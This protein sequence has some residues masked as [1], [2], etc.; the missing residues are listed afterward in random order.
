MPQNQLAFLLLRHATTPVRASLTI[1]K[2]P[3][4][5]LHHVI[6]RGADAASSIESLVLK[7]PHTSGINAL[8]PITLSS[9]PNKKA[10]DGPTEDF[11]SLSILRSGLKIRFEV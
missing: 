11:S 8:G 3:L 5:V 7:M 6:G 9:D 4:K 10:I 1:A 2:T